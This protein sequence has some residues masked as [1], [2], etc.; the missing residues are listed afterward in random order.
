MRLIE[1]RAESE[2]KRKFEGDIVS[3]VGNAL[4]L[5]HQYNID[6]EKV[7]PKKFPVQN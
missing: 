5:A 3:V 6:L 1:K 2:L 7:I 4:I